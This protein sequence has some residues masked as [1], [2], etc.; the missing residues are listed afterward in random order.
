MRGNIAQ[1]SRANTSYERGVCPS[2][3]LSHA[4]NVPKLITVG[5][6]GFHHCYPRDSIVLWW[7]EIA[8]GRSLEHY[9]L[10]RAREV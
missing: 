1:I 6:Y 7:H 9:P 3:R 5:S 2:V 10:C 4:G 8:Y